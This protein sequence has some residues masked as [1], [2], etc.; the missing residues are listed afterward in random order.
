V[1]LP[2]ATRALNA[3]YPVTGLD[4]FHERVEHI[5]ATLPTEDGILEVTTDASALREADIILIRVPTPIKDDLPD[6]GQIED[7]ARAGSAHIA[8]GRLVVLEST[9][10]LA[11]RPLGPGH[12]RIAARS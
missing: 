6:M 4:T 5:S 1:G 2:P 7:A 12:N 3:G 11:H 10:P 8:K 9:S